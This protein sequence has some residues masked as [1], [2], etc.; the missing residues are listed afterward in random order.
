MRPQTD[1]A[2]Q[3]RAGAWQCPAMEQIH[4]PGRSWCLRGHHNR[5]VLL[6][7]PRLITLVPPRL[8][9]CDPLEIGAQESEQHASSQDDAEKFADQKMPPRYRLTHERDCRASFDL[10]ADGHA[11]SQGAKNRSDE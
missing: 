8:E 10:F 2:Q 4:D 5:G 11:G 6:V 7:P 3:V 9:E 1:A